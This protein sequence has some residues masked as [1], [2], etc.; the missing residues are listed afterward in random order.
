MPSSPPLTQLV[1][2]SSLCN[3][4]TVGDCTKKECACPYTLDI[5]LGSLVEVLLIDEG[6]IPFIAG[7]FKLLDPTDSNRENL[8]CNAPVSFARLVF[9]CRRHGEDWKRS[10]GRTNSQ[11]G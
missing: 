2:P 8:E 11:D 3:E 10:D 6:N 1:P 4:S 7:R 9:P 5:T